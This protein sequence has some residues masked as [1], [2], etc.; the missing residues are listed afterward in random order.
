MLSDIEIHAWGRALEYV[1][2]AF[3][4]H[5]GNVDTSNMKGYELGV[6]QNMMEDFVEPEDRDR[7]YDTIEAFK[8]GY[9]MA[10]KTALVIAS[11]EDTN[12]GT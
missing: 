4:L 2:Y 3:N 1:N 10:Y 5:Y 6:L 7:F 8:R 9:M 12:E 11:E